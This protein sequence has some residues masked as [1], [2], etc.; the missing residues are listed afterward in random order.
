MARHDYETLTTRD[1][2]FGATV[3]YVG[4]GKYNV[5]TGD[6]RQWSG[7]LPDQR[8]RFHTLEECPVTDEFDWCEQVPFDVGSYSVS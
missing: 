4:N 7:I 6:D 8:H 1:E 5:I 3:V 2:I